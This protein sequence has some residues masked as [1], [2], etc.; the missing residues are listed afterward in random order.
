[1][2]YT[3]VIDVGRLKKEGEFGSKVWCEACAAVAVKIL[4][5]AD[6]PAGLA[7]GFTEHYL[8]PP[9]RMLDGGREK[10]GYFVLVNEGEVSGGDGVPNEAL[11]VPG[12]HIK[13]RWAAICSQSGVLYGQSGF[14][15]RV[16]ETKS[17]FDS[18]ERYLGRK[19]LSGRQD[20]PEVFWPP[21]IAG[22]LMAGSEE[23][24][25]LHNIAA[26]MQTD[27]P[28]FSGLPLTKMRVP[29]FEAMSEK[30]KIY[31]LKLLNLVS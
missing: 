24:N 31:F 19:N 23:G 1:M 7:W 12:L 20:W 4:E 18:I 6:I 30:Q 16:K 26:T 2:N 22:P 29:I 3:P 14:E 13:A 17:M 5:K 27:S 9:K 15:Q 21:E 28:E 11:S 10:S 8:F 25:G